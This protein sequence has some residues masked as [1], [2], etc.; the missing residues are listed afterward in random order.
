[1]TD[2]WWWIT[3]FGDSAVTLPLAF[4]VI[5]YLVFILHRRRAG[6]AL[7]LA[8]GGTAFVLLLLKLSFRACTSGGGL[9]T[10]PSGHVA[11]SAV[12]YGC[13]AIL[14]ARGTAWRLPI[15]AGTALFVLAVAVS[16]LAIGAHN[17][18]E[19]LTGMGVGTGFSVAF[20]LSLGHEPPMMHRRRQLLVIAALAILV[21]FGLNPPIEEAIAAIASDLQG[22]IPG[23][24]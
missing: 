6:V 23:C 24:E 21:T 1:M 8:T 18:P 9:I 10:S 11:M 7:A 20:G 14:M 5:V 12:V 4:L 19:V 16:R 3:D 22:R 17:L 2:F 15:L 13:L